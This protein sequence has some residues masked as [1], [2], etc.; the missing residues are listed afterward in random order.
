MAISDDDL[1]RL[2]RCV[3]LAREALEQGD[4]PFG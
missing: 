1:E 2:G 3:E 4:E